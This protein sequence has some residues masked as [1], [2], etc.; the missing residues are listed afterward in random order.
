MDRARN[1]SKSMIS[2]LKRAREQK[3]FLLKE[4]KE[5][6]RGKRHLANMMGIE[7]DS[8]TQVDVDDAIKYLFPSGLFDK[9]ARPAMKH[10]SLIYKAQ[11]DAQFDVEGRPFHHLFYTTLP[12]YYE[13]LGEIGNLARELNQYEDEQL[14]QGVTNPPDDLRFRLAGQ[15]WISYQEA[16][17]KLLENISES[18]YQFLTNSLDKLIDHPYS[19]RVENFIKQYIKDLPGQSLNLKLPELLKDEKTGHIYTEM[20]SKHREHKVKVKTILNGTG[21]FNYE[22]HDILFFDPPY[23]RRAILFPLQVSKMLDKVD[24]YAHLTNADSLHT[25]GQGTIATAIRY[26]ISV[27]IGAYVDPE[28]REKMRLCG[29]LTPDTR[30][31]ERKKFGQEG[32]R[33]KYTWKKR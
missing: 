32:A 25:K 1:I 12:N 33:R 15:E 28:T 14:A 13:C 20:I 8:M 18:E 29:L 30:T 6:E 9:R 3:E 19:T 27:S 26:A 16:C 11:K 7:A 31:K 24:V 10:P 21:I 17:D 5:F 23:M 2:Y 4:T 22:G